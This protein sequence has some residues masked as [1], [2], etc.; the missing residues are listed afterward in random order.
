[1]KNLTA[2]STNE[3]YIKIMGNFNTEYYCGHSK[4]LSTKLIEN[5]TVFENLQD[6][7]AAVKRLEDFAHDNNWIS[8]SF[9]ICDFD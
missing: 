3:H 6:A 8:V 2:T 1:M 4:D 7:E 9:K 5:S